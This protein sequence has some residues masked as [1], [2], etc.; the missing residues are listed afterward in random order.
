MTIT[1]LDE[2]RGIGPKTKIVLLKE[3]KSIR[4][5]KATSKEE[6]SKHI[7]E[8]KAEILIQYFAK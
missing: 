8:R 6:L 1:E 5:I 3:F 4:K 7:G 2:I